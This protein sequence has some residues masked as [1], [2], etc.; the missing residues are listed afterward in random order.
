MSK[1]APTPG[2]SALLETNSDLRRSPKIL[3]PNHR[4][5]AWL[6]VEIALQWLEA[7]NSYQES[8]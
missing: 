2:Q 8:R 4:L 5:P 1:A 3:Y 6:S 7:G